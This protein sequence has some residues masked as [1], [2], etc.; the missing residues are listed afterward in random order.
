MLMINKARKI[1]ESLKSLFDCSDRVLEIWEE[2]SRC[3]P[4]ADNRWSSPRQLPE[5][6]DNRQSGKERMT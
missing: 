2:I 4:D 3:F 6:R 5:G 1:E